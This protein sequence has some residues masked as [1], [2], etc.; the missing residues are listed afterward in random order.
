M[1]ENDFFA[2]INDLQDFFAQRENVAT[3]VTRLLAALAQGKNV[4]EILELSF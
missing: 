3:A 2:L 1:G 4:Q